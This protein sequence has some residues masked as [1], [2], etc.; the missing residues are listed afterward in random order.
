MVY[1]DA[2]SDGPYCCTC[3]CDAIRFPMQDAVKQ[4]GDS[5]IIIPD[6]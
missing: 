5:S 1:R 3:Y 2:G 4:C 6:Q